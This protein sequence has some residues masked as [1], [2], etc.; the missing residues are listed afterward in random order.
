MR[1]CL[2]PQTL[3]VASGPNSGAQMLV[4]PDTDVTLGASPR[5]KPRKQHDIISTEKSE[6]METN[7]IGGD[8]FPPKPLSLYVQRSKY[9]PKE[10]I[11]KINYSF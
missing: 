5:K 4:D 3:S 7:S 9:P 1:Q 6:K 8:K 11:G 10:Y 2:S